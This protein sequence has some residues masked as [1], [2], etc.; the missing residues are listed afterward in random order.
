VPKTQVL[1]N[2]IVTLNAAGVDAVSGNTDLWIDD[3]RP[4][5]RE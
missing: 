5:T 4:C 2:G 1:E 3:L